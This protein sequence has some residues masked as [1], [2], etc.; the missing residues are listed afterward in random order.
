MRCANNDC[1]VVTQKTAAQPCTPSSMPP[2]RG[3][4]QTPDGS[5]AEGA[6]VYVTIGQSLPLSSRTDSAGLWVVPMTNL[7]KQDLS[8]LIELPDS[9]LLQISVKR[10]SQ[11]TVTA[12]MDV[13]SL[14][15]NVSLPPLIFGNSYN[16]TDLISKRKG[17]IAQQE[18]NKTLG[19]AT[20]RFG[21]AQSLGA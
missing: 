7:R 4:V 3:T 14:R 12:V 21:T 6:L 8:E 17:I 19:V 1:P 15:S 5:P 2:L 13:R 16:L 9:D 18:Q 11:E 20:N 10:A